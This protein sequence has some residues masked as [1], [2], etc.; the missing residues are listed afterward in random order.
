ML[1]RQVTVNMV[2]GLHVRPISMIVEVV[3]DN[4]CFVQIR[5]GNKQVEA[6]SQLNLM[7]L[8]APQ[9]SELELL[10]EGE[11]AE[12]VLDHLENLFLTNF[13]VEG[14]TESEQVI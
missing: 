14:T 10:A 9:G 8:A 12:Q 6:N 3:N 1:R 4:G 2:E 13:E 11:G 5:Y 7:L